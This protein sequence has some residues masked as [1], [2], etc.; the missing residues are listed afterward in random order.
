M[1]S[2]V[3]GNK[4]V[5]MAAGYGSGL[6]LRSGPDPASTDKSDRQGAQAGIVN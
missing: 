5:L 4:P 3:G 2:V 6:D 1:D